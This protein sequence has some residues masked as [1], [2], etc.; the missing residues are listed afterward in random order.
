MSISLL[1]LILALIC[2]ILAA[3]SVP[4]PRV[5]LIALGLAFWVAAVMIAGGGLALR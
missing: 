2:F 1:C 4:V 3:C 5:N